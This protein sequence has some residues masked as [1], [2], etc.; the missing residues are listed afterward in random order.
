MKI[1]RE[2]IFGPVLSIISYETVDEAVEIANDSPYGLNGAVFGPND[3]AH[4]VAT[5][6]KTGN[7]FINTADKPLNVPFGGYK[8]S[9]IGRK[10]GFWESKN[11]SNTKHS[12]NSFIHL[13]IS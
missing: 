13:W 11:S 1:A 6:M 5:Q 3:L 8:Y 9:G 4:Q 7:I 10:T 12:L 2:E